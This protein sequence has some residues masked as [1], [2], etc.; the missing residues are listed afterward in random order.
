[1]KDYSKSKVPIIFETLEIKGISQK[2][3]AEAI[4]VSTGNISDWKSGKS[5]P[6]GEVV[7]KIAAFLDINPNQIYGIDMPKEKAANYPPDVQSLWERY[8]SLNEEQKKL[9]DGMIDQLLEKK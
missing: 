4:Q 2:Q 3:L 8:S 1:M 5:A 7:I 9:V 6:V